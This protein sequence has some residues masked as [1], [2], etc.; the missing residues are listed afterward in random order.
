MGSFA[1][2]RAN[3]RR[4]YRHGGLWSKRFRV[5]IQRC[6]EPT[7]LLRLAP[8]DRRQWADN[9][10]AGKRGAALRALGEA[11]EITGHAA[12]ASTIAQ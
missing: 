12:R 1:S 10:Q 4:A 9:W 5:R 8:V 3:R 7:T 6:I 11:V 2:G